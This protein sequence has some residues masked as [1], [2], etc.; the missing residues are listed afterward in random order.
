[1]IHIS[2]WPPK[3]CHKQH[4]NG[5]NCNNFTRQYWHLSC[6]VLLCH[7]H[8]T[9][10][11]SILSLRTDPRSEMSMHFIYLPWASFFS[12]VFFWP[13]IRILLHTQPKNEYLRKK[14][15]KK[16][17]VVEGMEE[18]GIREKAVEKKRN[19]DC[20][21]GSKRRQWKKLKLLL[22]FC[23]CCSCVLLQFFSIHPRRI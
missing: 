14:G 8:K 16:V 13:I 17:W 19:L 6:L 9:S 15:R 23:Y 1:M 20:E 10:K 12:S 11:I 7:C 4:E 5:D 2:V 3:N 21:G 18:E 22:L